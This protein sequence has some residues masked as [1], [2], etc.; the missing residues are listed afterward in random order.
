MFLIKKKILLSNEIVYFDNNNNN[1]ILSL[2]YN[3]NN[4]LNT[5]FSKNKKVESVSTFS[6]Q[7][8]FIPRLNLTLYTLYDS[9]NCKGIYMIFFYT[10]DFC[11]L[12]V[13]IVR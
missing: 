9:K 3:L 6:Y 8:E 12:G 13:K 10:S 5:Q 7:E 2:D 1:N 4:I 11:I